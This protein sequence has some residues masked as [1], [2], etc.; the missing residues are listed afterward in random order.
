MT[1]VNSRSRSDQS[2]LRVLLLGITG[3]LAL[4]TAGLI[5][6]PSGF[7]AST[8]RCAVANLRVDRIGTE[9]FT[10]H[11]SWDMALRN[12]G[13]TACHLKG[14]PGVA[15]LDN[16][17]RFMPTT[18]DH[19]F[20][21]PRTVVLRPWQRGFFSFTYVTNGPCSRA[22]FAYGIQIIA[23]TALQRLVWYA[24]RFGLCGPAPAQVTVSPVL[25]KRPF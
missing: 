14:F 1:L 6:P 23:P 8:P 24:G 7:G 25:A 15:L 22:V 13:S 17:A 16:G 9:G 21:P 4:A 10:S 5:A 12:V 18:V 19:R 3:A 20:G 2:R 11:A